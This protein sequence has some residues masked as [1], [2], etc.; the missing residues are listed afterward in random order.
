MI[1]W[2]L[3]HALS[4]APTDP[5][6]ASNAIPARIFQSM[7]HAYHRWL[8]QGKALDK[9]KVCRGRKGKLTEVRQVHDLVCRIRTLEVCI[10]ILPVVQTNHRSRRSEI[11]FGL[12]VERDNKS[13]F[14][15]RFDAQPG[16]RERRPG[17]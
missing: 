13:H 16:E 9:P 6:L 2:G 7:R 15:L 1:C 8:A 3:P 5:A 12:R 10:A 4:T 17:A 11:A 14:Q